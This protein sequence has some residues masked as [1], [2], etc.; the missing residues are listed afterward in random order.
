[1]IRLR[2]TAVWLKQA[3]L[4]SRYRD[5][6]SRLQLATRSVECLH[7]NIAPTI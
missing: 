4:V 2:Y 5:C 7:L 3:G 6:Q 1:M